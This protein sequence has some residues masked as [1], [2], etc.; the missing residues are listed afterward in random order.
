ML[1]FVG[2]FVETVLRIKDQN[3]DKDL[4]VVFAQSLRHQIRKRPEEYIFDKISASLT[5]IS[6][7]KTKFSQFKFV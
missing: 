2:Y 3:E 5:H 7:V 1:F 4:R 6:F